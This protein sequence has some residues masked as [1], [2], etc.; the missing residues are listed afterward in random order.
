MLGYPLH[1]SVEG[2]VLF[3][4]GDDFD[5]FFF[6]SLQE[7][8]LVRNM[9][10]LTCWR[11]GGSLIFQRIYIY[12][13]PILRIAQLCLSG[14]KILNVLCCG[15]TSSPFPSV[16]GKW[17]E[18]QQA[19]EHT[20]SL[21]CYQTPCSLKKRSLGVSPNIWLFRLSSAVQ[22]LLEGDTKSIPNTLL[23]F[24]KCIDDFALMSFI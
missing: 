18:R 21:Y 19:N 8:F 1:R 20:S 2:G 5:F 12:I 16:N 4:K 17:K 24:K 9:A 15:F 11:R 7:V 13:N 14:E 10:M 22:G 6:I 23:L 3:S